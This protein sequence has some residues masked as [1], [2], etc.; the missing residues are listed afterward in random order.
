MFK[1]GPSPKVQQA[2]EKYLASL[3]SSRR[4]LTDE[5]WHIITKQVKSQR[6]V[7]PTI[8]CCLILGIALIGITI[9]YCR[10][11]GYQIERAT[12][13]HPVYLREA[14]EG[15][16]IQLSPQEIK[17]YLE[18]LSSTSFN[19]G[20]AFILGVLLLLAALAV[21]SVI[22]RNRKKLEAFIP[23]PTDEPRITTPK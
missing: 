22:R 14:G 18:L 3:G 12:P 8:L 1:K 15:G 2:A 6:M 16:T 4:Q 5:Q 19:T 23:R 9:F 21:P 17:D 10:W 11:A 7:W 20:P 13:D